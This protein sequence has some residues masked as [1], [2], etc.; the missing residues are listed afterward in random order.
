MPQLLLQIS[1]AENAGAGVTPAGTLK[2]FLLGRL[3][4]IEVQRRFKEWRRDRYG[5]AAIP[6]ELWSA[7]IPPACKNGVN[8]TATTL[9][10]DDR[11]LKRSM[12]EAG[13][14][15]GKPVS[16][17][18]VEPMAPRDGTLAESTIEF[19]KPAWQGANPI[20]WRLVAELA[21]LGRALWD[22]VT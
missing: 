7:A 5:R 4:Q 12:V 3:G 2:N 9:H 1:L 14:I 21:D 8:R 19:G 10:L 15:V 6:D 17:T 13:A 18:F 22:A 16:P 11:K 20:K